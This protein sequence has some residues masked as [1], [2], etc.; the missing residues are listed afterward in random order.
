M[1]NIIVW[2]SIYSSML[3]IILVKSFNVRIDTKFLDHTEKTMICNKTLL[4]FK[5]ELL[6]V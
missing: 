5:K 3:S 4:Q 1:N 6:S 2:T